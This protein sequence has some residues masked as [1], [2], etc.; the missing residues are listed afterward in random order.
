MN[1]LYIIILFIVLTPGIIFRFKDNKY[2]I[3]AIHA[4]IFTGFFSINDKNRENFDANPTSILTIVSIALGGAILGIMLA[5]NGSSSPG[6]AIA[7][8]L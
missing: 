7:S 1:Y 2:M 8:T 3:A 5:S 4:I 6:L